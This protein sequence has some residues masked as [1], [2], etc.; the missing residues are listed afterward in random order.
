MVLAGFKIIADDVTP[1][2]RQIVEGIRDAVQN[3]RLIP[4]RRLPPTRALARQLGVNRNTV[5]AAYESLVEE[6][7]VESHTGR[8]TFITASA[9]AGGD[10]PEHAGDDWASGFSRAV[11]GPLVGGLLSFYRHAV[12]SGNISLAGSYPAAE[13]MPVETFGRAIKA[14]LAER[15]AALFSYGPTAGDPELRQ[16]IA[17][18]MRARGSVADADR[19]VVTQGAQQAIDLVFHAFA[20][21]DDAVVV[22][23]PTYTGALSVLGSLG[24]RIVGIPVD[25]EGMRPDLL[26]AALE[27]HRPRLV[28]L[29]P[30]FHN[31]TTA[32][33]GEARRRELLAVAERYRVVVVEDDWAGGLRF[34][35]SDPPT[36]HA[37]DG[38]R[39]VLYIGSFSKQLLPG[40]RLGWIAAPSAV[41]ERL[42]ALKQ[43][44]DCGSSPLV[45]ASLNTFLRAGGLD[46]HLRRVVPAYRGRRDTMLAALA[47][48]FPSGTRWTRPEG[49][50]FVW[51]TLP[52]QIDGEALFVAAQQRGVSYSK[53]DVF[54]ST[55]GG[56]NRL[57]LTFSVVGSGDIEVGMARL[58]AWLREHPSAGVDAQRSSEAIPIL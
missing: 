34:A 23:E 35:G 6:G 26:T 51:V 1:V 4:G 39:R 12:A 58:G 42:V 31:P 27:R 15:G 24:A 53:G 22:E 44:R 33:M 25:D 13:L 32:V 45:Q 37:L 55:G 49:G 29:Q 17:E 7:W 52:D 28:Y 20:E 48:E 9:A 50:L 3:G 47:R 8:G 41:T 43:I 30:S 19:I 54:H 14:T 18:R 40:L 36:L 46:E 11:E 16:S 2:Y 5:V 56:R 57:R 38:G 21:R 10:S